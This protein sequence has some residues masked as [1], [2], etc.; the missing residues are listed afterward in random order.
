M[1]VQ[2]HIDIPLT[3][4]V[5]VPDADGKEA[6]RTKLTLRRP[7]TRHAKRLA[8]AIGPDLVNGLMAGGDTDAVDMTAL[9]S[10][11]ISALVSADRLE[12]LTAIIADMCGEKVE[13]IDDVDLVDL[14][15]VGVA[16]ADFFPALRS[17][18]LSKLQ[19]PSPPSTDGS[20][21]R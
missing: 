16:F 9:A 17:F 19:P 8:V 12:A 18:G 4:P 20:R 5:P 14:V 15:K 21:A 2:D 7:K 3:Y 6:R 10:Q 1:T 11:V 13:V